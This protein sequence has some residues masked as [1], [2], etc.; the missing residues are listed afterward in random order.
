MA[1]LFPPVQAS[2]GICG[3]HRNDTVYFSAS[4]AQSRFSPRCCG[5]WA[6]CSPASSVRTDLSETRPQANKRRPFGAGMSRP[7]SRAVSSHSMITVSAFASASCREEPSAAQPG[8]SDTSAINAWSSSLQYRMISYLVIEPLQP[9][10]TGLAASKDPMPVTVRDKLNVALVGRTPWS[11]R[12]A[13]V[14]RPEQRYQHLARCER[15]TGASAAD[16]GVRP[17]ILGGFSVVGKVGG[18]CVQDLRHISICGPPR[19]RIEALRT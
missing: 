13:L 18:M 4:G 15:P 14:P 16:Q 9:A 1:Q 5:L 2:S 19:G 11:A 7:S 10:Y 8:S 17:T 12:D 3:P 6:R